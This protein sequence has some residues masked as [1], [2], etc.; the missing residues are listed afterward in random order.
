MSYN[1]SES[2]GGFI[3]LASAAAVATAAGTCALTTSGTGAFIFNGILKTLSAIVNQVP[4]F[5]PS[6]AVSTYQGQIAPKNLLPNQKCMFVF[7]VD[8]TGGASAPYCYVVQGQVVD[9]TQ[10][11]PVPAIQG[12]FDPVSSSGVVNADSGQTVTQVTVGLVPIAA[13]TV[14]T[15]SA[16]GLQLPAAWGAPVAAAITGVTFYTTWS[17]LTG[18]GGTVTVYQLATWPANS[19]A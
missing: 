5:L 8:Y 13:F 6:G 10:T 15:T 3:N 2:N 4:T 1:I 19:L 16:T 17:G 9:S 7:L 18:A 11:A 12:A 14:T